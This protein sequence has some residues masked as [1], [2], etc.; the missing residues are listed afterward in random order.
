MTQNAR[1]VGDHHQGR[2]ALLQRADG[3]QQGFLSYMVETR[4]RF[5]EHDE[6]GAAVNGA[7]K[8]NLLALPAGKN[9]AAVTNFRIVPPRQAQDHLMHAREARGR[10]HL[11]GVALAHA[12]DVLA[13]GADEQFDI[14]GQV[15]DVT[16]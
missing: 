5:V 16:A 7:R 9:G 2:P 12:G 6:L 13:H 8:R 10:D 14:L 11:L 3:F 15:T 4:A 1:P